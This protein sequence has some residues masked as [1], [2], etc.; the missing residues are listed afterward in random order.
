MFTH[1][2]NCPLRQGMHLLQLPPNQPTA[3]RSPTAKPSTSSPS[4]A[5]VPAI[6]WPK[7]SGHVMFGK[8]PVTKAWS[9]PHTPQAATAMRICPGPGGAVSTSTIFRGACAAAT[10][11]ALCVAIAGPYCDELC[12]AADSQG[13]PGILVCHDHDSPRR[14]DHQSGADAGFPGSDQAHRLLRR[15]GPG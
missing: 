8:P 1:C 13:L 6:S 14:G 4:S 12:R 3:T 5:M 15:M 7:V 9:V 10:C 2:M 11:T